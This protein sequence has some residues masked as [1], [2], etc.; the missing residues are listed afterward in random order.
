MFILT[1]L[2]A[3]T[4]AFFIDLLIGDPRWL[5]HPVVGMGK[6]ISILEKI[7]NRGSARKWKGL[8]FLLVFLTIIATI[9]ISILLISYHLH[10][11]FGIF[12]E[13][14][15]ISTT[16]ATKGLKEAA[17]QVYVPLK[18][19]D[20]IAARKNLAMIVG[21]DTEMLDEQEIVRGAVETVA[22]NTSDGITAPLFF[23]LFGGGV[24]AMIY[25]AV[26]TCDSMVGYKN[27]RY[28]QFGW[29]SAR[30]DDVLNYF[31]SRLTAFVML[32]VNSPLEKKKKK[33]CVEILLRDARKHPSPNS[34][35]L[36]AA[37][38]SLLGV[39]L[40][41]RNTYKGIESIRAHMGDPVK[42]LEK[43][44]IAYGN[45]MMV[46]TCSSFLITLWIIGGVIVALT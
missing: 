7:F 8:L 14:I 22:E 31:P 34:G 1:H 42:P 12:V 24:F 6:L 20:L 39:Q 21:R 35:W 37:M 15:L 13:A 27:E 41:G 2:L 29:A 10:F 5:P 25:R 44:H 28:H 4:L 36:E 16:I 26:N 18:E 30:F 23:A 19:N 11:V 45:Q 43:E 32:L 3:L 33:D 46:R 17:C 40:G 38:A 9:V